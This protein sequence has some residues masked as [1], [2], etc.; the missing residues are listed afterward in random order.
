MGQGLSKLF[1]NLD[2]NSDT[3]IDKR[4]WGAFGRNP[5]N[6]KLIKAAKTKPQNQNASE[7]RRRNALLNM[8]P[9][10]DPPCDTTCQRNKKENELKEILEEKKTNVVTAPDQLFDARKN[11]LEYTDGTSE[12]VKKREKELYNSANKWRKN[13]QDG[14]KADVK[15]METSIDAYEDSYNSLT[16]LDSFYGRISLSNSSLKREYELM[17]SKNSTNDRKAFYEMQGTEDLGWWYMIMKWLYI[18]LII[19]F[20]VASFLTPTTYSWK[21]RGILLAILILYPFVISSIAVTSFAS[22]RATLS[23]IPYNTYT[24]ALGVSFPEEN[25][26]TKVDPDPSYQVPKL[27]VKI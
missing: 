26:R 17:L 6:K 3:R 7:L 1:T 13:T 15:K 5:K 9:G 2:A 4:E 27:D 14:W 16:E 18:L 12:Y 20:I 10:I 24:Q 25:T 11:Y 8:F 23:M 19:S 21:V 22:I